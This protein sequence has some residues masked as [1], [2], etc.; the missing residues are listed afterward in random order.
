MRHLKEVFEA[1]EIAVLIWRSSTACTVKH[2]GWDILLLN[3]SKI[4]VGTTGQWET[5]TAICHKSDRTVGTL[6]NKQG[7]SVRYTQQTQFRIENNIRFTHDA[8]LFKTAGYDLTREM[9]KNGHDVIIP[10]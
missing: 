7:A 8:C 2:S 1:L 6:A 4:K 3:N 5:K 10:Q 9:D